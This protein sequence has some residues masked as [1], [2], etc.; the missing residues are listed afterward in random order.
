MIQSVGTRNPPVGFI[1]CRQ[2]RTEKCG[3]LINCSCPNL[4]SKRGER[5]II[6]DSKPF[7][8]EPPALVCE[9]GD[10]MLTKRGR[11]RGDMRL[12]DLTK[13]TKKI[14]FSQGG[15]PCQREDVAKSTKAGRGGC[16]LGVEWLLW[17]V[18]DHN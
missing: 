13:T 5:S 4:E 12:R 16:D 9:G 10:S 14:A 17:E 2:T 3:G 18:V 8:R 6:R 1:G 7:D 15:I 11:L